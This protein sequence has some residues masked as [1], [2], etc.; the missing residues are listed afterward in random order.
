M[1]RTLARQIPHR[2]IVDFRSYGHYTGLALLLLS[3]ELGI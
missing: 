3:V 2:T 1:R